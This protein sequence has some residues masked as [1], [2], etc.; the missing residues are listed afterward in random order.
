MTIRIIDNAGSL[1]EDDL[2]LLVG[3]DTL[4]A[5]M[6]TRIMLVVDAKDP[7]FDWTDLTDNLGGLY[8][9][10]ELTRNRLYQIWFEF[11]YDLDQFKKNLYM[12][13]LSLES[14]TTV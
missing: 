3:T 13:K 14:K 12:V 11:T 5:M 1:S 7:Q 10:R 8:H 2:K 4:Q 6:R 9:I